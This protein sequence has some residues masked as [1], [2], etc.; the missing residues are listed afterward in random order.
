[1]DCR[2]DCGDDRSRRA[3]SAVVPGRL[4]SDNTTSERPTAAASVH[5]KSTN[6][7]DRLAGEIN[8]EA[9]ALERYR[10]LRSPWRIVNTTPPSVHRVVIPNNQARRRGYGPA[11]TRYS[12]SW[13]LRS[14]KAGVCGS[15]WAV[16]ARLVLTR[17]SGMSGGNFFPSGRKFGKEKGEMTN[18]IC[19][20]DRVQRLTRLGVVNYNLR[21]CLKYSCAFRTAAD[22]PSGLKTGGN[23]RT[24]PRFSGDMLPRRG[25]VPDAEILA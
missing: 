1:M 20:L 5:G 13:V 10:S 3:A 24:R 14:T 6:R 16:V 22:R 7:S 12:F 9:R 23:R 15:V 2:R 4:P 11:N 17:G 8:Q 18:R 19:S 25:R 21:L